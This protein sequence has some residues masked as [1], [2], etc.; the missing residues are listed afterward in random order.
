MKL[1]ITLNIHIDQ[2][3]VHLPPGSDEPDADT[4]ELLAA[5]ERSGTAM[6]GAMDRL[7]QEVA[8]AKTVK[9]SAKALLQRLG[10][11]IRDNINNEAELN[12]LADEL[13]RD[14]NDLATAVTENTP[15]ENEPTPEEPGGGL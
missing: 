4:R 15:A 11:Q 14:S 2:L 5:L 13:D 9:E 12:R 3:H 6:A 10:Q 7:R 8:E 1:P